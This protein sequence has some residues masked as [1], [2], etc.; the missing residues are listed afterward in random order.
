MFIN[1]NDDNTDFAVYG[2]TKNPEKSAYF[3]NELWFFCLNKNIHSTCLQDLWKKFQHPL[4]RKEITNGTFHYEKL[5]NTQPLV[6]ISD[7]FDLASESLNPGLHKLYVTCTQTALHM[8]ENLCTILIPLCKNNLDLPMFFFFFFFLP[9]VWL[10]SSC[11][12]T[13]YF[14][15]LRWFFCLFAFT[16]TKSWF[17]F[18]LLCRREKYNLKGLLGLYINYVNRILPVTHK[19]VTYKFLHQFCSNFLFKILILFLIIFVFISFDLLT[20]FKHTLM[21]VIMQFYYY[22]ANFK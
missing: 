13:C 15:A 22:V 17:P 10:P 14:A 9:C 7:I 2:L 18:I 12:R 16:E 8:H 19:V 11:C 1:V 21:W 5:I 4:E 3:E 6:C 20:V